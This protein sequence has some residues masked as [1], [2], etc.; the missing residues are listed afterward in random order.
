MESAPASVDPMNAEPQ[1]LHAQLTNHPFVQ[2]MESSHVEMMARIAV[3]VHFAEGEQVFHQ[4]GTADRLFLVLKGCIALEVYNADYGPIPIQMVESGDVL[5]S[6]WFVPLY[7]LN[8]D[9]KAV[10]D[11]TA[12]AF[13]G[14]TL[15]EMCD[16]QLDF[17]YDLMK[18]MAS[19]VDQ[20]LNAARD[21]LQD[22]YGS[23]R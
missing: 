2:G 15:L 20:R 16:R 10:R 11:T 18:R 22:V 7:E 13:D 5:G 3:P 21:H 1:A 4:G 17:G 9:A 8:F 19:I 6:S 12:L 14:K 23:S